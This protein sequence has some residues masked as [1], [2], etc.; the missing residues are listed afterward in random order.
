MQE[1]ERLRERVWRT[2]ANQVGPVE[3]WRRVRWWV[4]RDCDVLHIRV[5]TAWTTHALV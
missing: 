4:M 5:L 1:D 3:S 2:R